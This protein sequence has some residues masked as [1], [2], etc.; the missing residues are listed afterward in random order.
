MYKTMYQKYQID[1]GKL[2]CK[3]DYKCPIK[4]DFPRQQAYSK[5]TCQQIPLYPWVTPKYNDKIREDYT[6]SVANIT[7][8]E[9]D[10]NKCKFYECPPKSKSNFGSVNQMYPYYKL[11]PHINLSDPPEFIYAMPNQKLIGY[12]Y[13]YEH[14]HHKYCPENLYETPWYGT[15]NAQ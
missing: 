10:G 6:A 7:T 11:G 12:G 2:D 3:Y 8:G 14:R 4:Y 9:T 15:Y 5:K 1:T 13:G